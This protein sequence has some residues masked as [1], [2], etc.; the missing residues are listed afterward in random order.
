MQKLKEDEVLNWWILNKT[1]YHLLLQIHL[2]SVSRKYLAAPS[3]SVYS[4]ILVSE[5]GNLY[6]QNRNRLLPKTG[7][8]IISPPELKKT[9]IVFCSI[10]ET[11]F[12]IVA[13]FIFL[14]SCLS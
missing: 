4:E 5:A 3:S 6:E 14:N 7:K 10:T 12:A 13:R 8:K 2:A 1:K 9:R 11:S